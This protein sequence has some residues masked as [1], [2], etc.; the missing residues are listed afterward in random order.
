VLPKLEVGRLDELGFAG[1]G[2]IASNDE[3]DDDESTT[4]SAVA[5]ADG[6]F[7]QLGLSSI[8]HNTTRVAVVFRTNA[9]AW[10]CVRVNGA[11]TAWS[12]SPTLPKR[13]VDFFTK[14]VR[15]A[16]FPNPITVLP[17][18]LVTVQTYDPD[19]CPYIVQYTPNTRR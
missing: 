9:P 16:R 5:A 4:R 12:L 18:T 6:A 17:L 2:L 1:P 13:G 14:T 10:S 15:V 11:V 8:E 19:C 7:V 3:S